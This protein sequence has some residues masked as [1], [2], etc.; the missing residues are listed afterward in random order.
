M[1]LMLRMSHLRI[2]ALRKMARTLKP[3]LRNYTGLNM[4]PACISGKAVS[5]VDLK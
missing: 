4:N 5:I 3:D 2:F 1:T